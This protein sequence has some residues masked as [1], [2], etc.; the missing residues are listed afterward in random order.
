MTTA[1]RRLRRASIAGLATIA[2]AGVTVLASGGTALAFQPAGATSGGGSLTAGT[3]VTVYPGMSS[4]ALNNITLTLPDGVTTAGNGWQNGDSVTL[5]L[6][7]QAG[8]ELCNTSGN[9]NASASLATPTVSA[10]D[11]ATS[12]AYTGFTVSQ[13]SGSTCNVNDQIVIHLTANAPSDTG[14]TA[15]T[16]SGLSLKLGTNFPGGNPTAIKV[17]A[18]A[19]N[20]APF[21][22]VGTGTQT[23]TS[24]NVA[25]VGSVSVNAGPSLGVVANQTNVTVGPIVTT[26]VV[27]GNLTTNI[28]YVLGAG[29]KWATAGTLTLPSGLVLT[30]GATAGTNTLTFAFSGTSTGGQTITLTG[31]SVNFDNTLGAHS[32]TVK[33]NAV[34]LGGGAQQIAF[35][36]TQN[37]IGGADRYGTAALIFNEAFGTTT[38]TGAGITPSFTA[39]T[40]ATSVVIASG[41]NF[42]DALSSSYLAA[43]LGTGILLTDPNSLP[44]ATQQVLINGN[45][46]TVYIVGGTAAVSQGVQNAIAALKN[47]TTGTNLNVIRVAGADRYATN[48]AADLN[49]GVVGSGSQTALL[50][51]GANFA[52]ALS[53]SPAIA[54]KHYPLILTTP[55]ALSPTASATITALG[56]K[57]VI[58]LGGTSAVSTTVETA[59]KALPGVTVLQRL[60]GAD[61]TQTAAQIATWET[62]GVAAGS[63]TALP[64]LGFNWGAGSNVNISNGANFPDALAAGPALA[65]AGAG[66]AGEPLL[67]TNTPTSLGA[68]IPAF[69]AGSSAHVSTV[70]AIGLASAVSPTVLAAASGSIS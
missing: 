15:F 1:T 53:A 39:P 54:A 5:Q 13:S 52:D 23:V 33:S 68:G 7:N 14:T 11:S 9:S 66:A 32:V 69:L 55:N 65:K 4:Q 43:S 20:G 70:S 3:S 64:A 22:T 36:G 44:S 27:G 28:Q 18:T 41:A 17:L 30:S 57:N 45:I 34:T 46:S 26:D 35:L 19:S 31:A 6:V 25:T 16:I 49:S 56:V 67:L 40:K 61:R 50:A 59:V 8:T 62:Q 2:T 24:A 21:G 48:Q 38:P 51:T 42:P 58:I 10:V 47:P 63:Y 60:A 37:R 12:A 29:D